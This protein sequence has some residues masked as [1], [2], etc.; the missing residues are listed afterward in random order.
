MQPFPLKSSSR[1]LIIRSLGNCLWLWFFTWWEKSHFKKMQR[2]QVQLPF[3]HKPRMCLL[4][5]CVTEN[6]LHLLTLLLPASALDVCF[7]HASALIW[8]YSF[9]S[10]AIST[11]CWKAVDPLVISP[12][13]SRLMVWELENQDSQTKLQWDVWGT[14]VFTLW[15]CQT[16]LLL[17]T[18]P[19]YFPMEKE[20][21]LY[22]SCS[23]LIPEHLTVCT[24]QYVFGDQITG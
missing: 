9:L 7:L 22:T 24:C 13:T 18:L 21:S 14:E 8:F 19:F 17:N 20:N 10:Y 1:D 6:T 2:K 11:V 4:P 23:S 15:T 5:P 3:L 16:V 12:I